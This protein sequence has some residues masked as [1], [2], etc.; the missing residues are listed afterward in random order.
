M[1]DGN[2]TVAVF[3]SL[4]LD[5]FPTEWVQA[6]WDEDFADVGTLPLEVK[7]LLDDAG[8]FVEQL[9][10]TLEVVAAWLM[11]NN[12]NENGEGLWSVLVEAEVSH[13]KLVA[14]LAH[15]THNASKV[16]IS[17]NER[18]AGV[19][20]ASLYLKLIALP[21]SAAFKIYN[22]ELFLQACRLLTKW[23][24]TDCN[25][26]RKR[27]TTPVR[28]NKKTKVGKKGK[29]TKKNSGTFPEDEDVADEEDQGNESVELTA[30]ES[31][32]LDEFMQQ[33]LKD[34][35]LICEKYSL[36]Q[37]ESTA[38]QLLSVLVDLSRVSPES[39]IEEMGQWNSAR[40]SP[41]ILI[42]KAMYLLCQPFHGHVTVLINEVCKLLL[43]H[44]LMV[45]DGKIFTNLARPVLTMRRCAL[46]FILY[47][48]K[49]LG[50]RCVAP[51]KTFLQHICFKVP[52]R[53]EYRTYAAEAVLEL[54][55]CFSDLDYAKILEWFK[56]LSKYNKVCQRSFVVEIML[57]L[58]EQ[59]ERKLSSEVPNDLAQF[60][61]H[62][63]ML[64]TMLSRC[65]DSNAGV[66]SRALVGFSVCINS[67]Q[68]DVVN[69]IKEVIT[70]V[71]TQGR[72]TA[73]HFM[74]TPQF[75]L[76]TVASENENLEE[77][78]VGTTGDIQENSTLPIEK[79]KTADVN[80][81][82]PKMSSKSFCHIELTPG[83][84]PYLPDTEGVIS[85]FHRRAFDTK[86]VVRKCALQALQKVIQLEAPLYRAEDL[87]VLQ[88]RCADP[89]L[90]VRKQAVQS[91]TELLEAFPQDKNIQKAWIFGLL[92]QV[93]D[94]ETSVQEKCFDHL[95][96]LI[97]KNLSA[98]RDSDSGIEWELLNIIA[99]ETCEKL[100]R[101]LQKACQYWARNKKLNTA[102]LKA[103]Q[104]HI[105]GANDRAAW[106]FLAEISKTP[107]NIKHEL[108]VN[109]WKSIKTVPDESACTTWV[110][111]LSVLGAIAKSIPSGVEEI[112]DDLKKKLCS[113]S[114]PPPLI[115][116]MVN[117]VS[118]L[119]NCL[120]PETSQ[121]SIQA[122][123]GEL[124][125]DCDKYLSHV[126]LQAENN[127]ESIDEEE[128]IRYM[129]TLGEVCQRCPTQMPKRVTLLIQS[130]VASPC[131]GEIG[132]SGDYHSE[133]QAENN[134]EGRKLDTPD[135]DVPSSQEQS[136]QHSL[137][138]SS[139]P[140]SQGT[141]ASSQPLSQFRGSKMS[142]KLR[143]H[144][145]ITLGKLCLVDESL[146]KKTV[147]ALARELEKSDSP[148]IRNNVVI[149]MG[150]LT[151][152]YTTLVDR[153]MTNIAACLKDPS[154][155]VR[156]NTL[157]IL[158]RLLQEEYVK[159]KGVLFFRYIT[160]LL[161]EVKEIKSLAEFCLEHLLLQKHPNMFFHPFI[162]CIFHFNN[163][164]THP[165]YNQF[166]QSDGEKQKFSLAGPQNANRR[167]SL[168]C[169]MLEHMTDEQRFK[170]T[171]KTNKEILS[172]IVD[173]II[174]LDADGA[175]LL[176]DALAILS[177]KEIKLST[178]RGRNTDDVPEEGADM[179]QI[180]TAT[181]KKV[182]ISQVVKRNVMEN[183]V[184]VVISLKHMLEKSRSSLL[185]D[186][187]G[188][189]RE[190]MKDYKSEI[191]DILA[192]DKQLAEEIAFDLRNFENRQAEREALA[193]ATT[194]ADGRRTPRPNTPV[195]S[196]TSST[197]T[198]PVVVSNRGTTAAV[199]VLKE[200]K[201]TQAPAD[202]PDGGSGRSSP[203]SSNPSSR[204]SSF[205]IVDA[206][207]KA[208]TRVDQLRQAGGPFSPVKLN[209]NSSVSCLTSS[210]KK[211]KHKSNVSPNCE[212]NEN[213]LMSP[214]RVPSQTRA[215][216]TPTDAMY[217]ITFGAD[218]NITM[219]PPSPIPSVASAQN[220]GKLCLSPTVKVQ[221]KGKKSIIHMPHP[222]A[223]DPE[224]VKWNIKSPSAVKLEPDA[225][226]SGD[227]TP[228]R[229][230][231]ASARAGIRRS[232]RLNSK[233]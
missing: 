192:D 82:T 25:S 100:R 180:V 45:E 209:K 157:T 140:S 122:W 233:Q 30:S 127:L 124:M 38:I 218:V 55:S 21:G 90:S 27:I 62:K 129:F 185:K 155:L 110:N 229:K 103:V 184:P 147:A 152:R 210:H 194:A 48:A 123:G 74:P 65:S 44:V 130:V 225:S 231:Y 198:S 109:H 88:E 116:G 141:V 146:A 202:V 156:K 73:K 42:Y 191:K 53:S 119:H 68:K 166:S 105:N 5:R 162:E 139:Q 173:K 47:L 144:A 80:S 117:C 114:Y 24:K 131:I 69:T 61:T 232:G 31:Q 216:S 23:S 154:A 36:R 179:A 32:R 60:A 171:A 181:A 203:A 12:E 132:S 2:T 219:L 168:Y 197:S 70:P 215:I 148:A 93:M 49:E 182:L 223:K 67:K 153:Y 6:C 108:V 159:W 51:I 92:P 57:A 40:S 170:I 128:M 175:S 29:K 8:Y 11:T 1:A 58:L 199:N 126:I 75:A 83:F 176:V 222:E 137:P 71:A 37:S 230:S 149:V 72:P 193:R 20:A 43:N 76:R 79:N 35:L 34:V 78:P 187:M 226:F 227:G 52:D 66:R 14:L 167:M 41:G 134:N 211:G 4:Q 195:V 151:I 214:V 28:A 64:C 7:N 111:V 204:R 228:T 77:T 183:I 143:A 189:L 99:D 97:L 207:K 46:H 120:D 26:K 94:R 163:Y 86:V 96:E 160:T 22:P 33:L 217:N 213:T 91:V 102:V 95:E 212:S 89:A 136:S 18:A 133:Q 113:F 9:E 19:L 208:M 190:L 177:S 205:S 206:A 188:Y 150:D 85:M 196:R 106:M 112:L 84:N 145:F 221:R 200:I 121:R 59:P 125:N 16:S 56:R 161:D 115:A 50:E 142:S 224:P 172:A 138:Q 54:L 81:N 164:Q 104:S 135:M 220:G 178:M 101:Y 107:V 13:K 10:S 87:A 39:T 186:L 63:S 98:S 118:R 15:L 174:P 3:E 201:I 17:F 165:V 169:F 158:T